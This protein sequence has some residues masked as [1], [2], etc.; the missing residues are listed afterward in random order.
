ML[1]YFTLGNTT[2]LDTTQC[3]FTSKYPEILD[4]SK[5]YMNDKYTYMMLRNIQKLK[6]RNGL[7]LN[8]KRSAL[9]KITPQIRKN[10]NH[11]WET[12]NL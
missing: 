6:T 11:K 3:Y 10:S 1:D 2:Q 9:D 12:N 8:W 4:W 7:Q 5:A